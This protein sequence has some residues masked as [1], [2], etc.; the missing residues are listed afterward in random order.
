MSKVFVLDT[1]KRPLDSQEGRLRIWK[2]KD[3]LIAQ[4]SLSLFV[5]AHKITQGTFHN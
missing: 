4:L 1:E 3:L 5:L 2:I